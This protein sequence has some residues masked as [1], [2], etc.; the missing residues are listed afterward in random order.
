MAAASTDCRWAWATAAGISVAAL[1]LSNPSPADFEAFAGERL[2]ELASKELCAPGGL[3]LVAQLVISNCPQLVAS[4]RQLLGQLAWAGSRR[5]NAGLFSLYTTELGG[6]TLLPGLTV[7]RYQ[8]L[9]LAGAG[10]L[11][12]LQSSQKESPLQQR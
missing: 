1:A 3:P 10:H 9:T 5:Y 4:Q 7:P 12:V 8:A 11:V 2:V 6:Q